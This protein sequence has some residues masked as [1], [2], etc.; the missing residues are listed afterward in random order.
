[1]SPLTY[2]KTGLPPTFIVHGDADPVMPY[3]QSMRLRA[4]LTAAHVPNELFTVPGGQH[5]KFTADQS[6]AI[7]AALTEFLKQNHL[8]PAR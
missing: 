7:G 2:V 1:M 6:L 5:G 3:E 4:A 8:L